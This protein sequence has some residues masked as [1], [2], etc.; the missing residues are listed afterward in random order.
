MCVCVCVSQPPGVA[1]TEEKVRHLEMEHARLASGHSLTQVLVH[2]TSCAQ[3][4][5][6]RYNGKFHERKISLI[7]Q[8]LFARV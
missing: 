3:S 1:H 5:D 2:M 8:N 7:D 6:T 4:Q